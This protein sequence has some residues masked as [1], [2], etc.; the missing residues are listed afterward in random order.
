M[1]RNFRDPDVRQQCCLCLGP[2]FYDE[3]RGN[4]CPDCRVVLAD[5]KAVSRPKPLPEAPHNLKVCKLHF[6]QDFH[7]GS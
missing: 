6:D 7:E 2:I 4:A 1:A 5:M 3:P